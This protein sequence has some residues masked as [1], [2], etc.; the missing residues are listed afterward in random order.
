MGVPRPVS[1]RPPM[2]GRVRAV[3]GFTF[4]E[5]LVV[6]TM[7]AVLA[8]AVLPLSKVTMQRQREVELRRGLRDM[9]TAID[10][11]KDAVTLQ[12]IGGSNV[13]MGNEGYPPDLETL[14]EGVERMNDASGTKLKFLR[15]IPF[16]PMTRGTEWGLRS[17]QDSPDST[18]W[19]G[20]NVYD[21][22]SRSNATALD[23]T[24]YNEW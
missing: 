8:S 7:L 6:S 10:R 12:Q 15:R 23:G 18:T 5:L 4:I 1:P 2:R 24:H 11:Y 13:E 21:V 17:Y 3:A 22:Y 14:V 20:D 19:G 16:D 9:R